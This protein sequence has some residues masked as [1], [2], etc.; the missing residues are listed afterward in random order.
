MFPHPP[1]QTAAAGWGGGNRASRGQQKREH[2]LRCRVE[3]HTPSRKS[4]GGPAADQGA[5]S[6]S[7]RC[8]WLLFLPPRIRAHLLEP[9]SLLCP[10]DPVLPFLSLL[11]P[12]SIRPLPL[13]HSAAHTGL[14]TSSFGLPQPRLPCG[15]TVN[16]SESGGVVVGGPVQEFKMQILRPCPGEESAGRP[17][18]LEETP[19]RANSSCPW[20]P[21]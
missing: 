10:R 20:W 9:C 1:P 18:S 2:A 8:C 4:R 3:R 12:G 19:L 5:A 7:P 11:L 16:L 17:R 15:L 14:L 13:S 6:G 21:V